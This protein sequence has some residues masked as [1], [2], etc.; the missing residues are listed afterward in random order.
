MSRWL[1]RAPSC[2]TQIPLTR[3]FCDRHAAMVETDTMRVLDR[4]FRPGEKP[5]KV[6]NATLTK[7]IEEITLYKLNGHRAPHQGDFEW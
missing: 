7:A 6:F 4:T 1:C 3:H 5:S 2:S